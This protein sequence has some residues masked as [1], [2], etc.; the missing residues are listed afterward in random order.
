MALYEL[1][2]VRPR[3]GRDV[4]VADSAAAIGHVELGDDASV[5]FGA[6]LRGDE[7]P[8]RVGARSNVQDNAVIHIASGRGP[9]TV[10]DDVTVGHAAIL[11]ACTVGHACLI[12]MGAI[13]STAP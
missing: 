1:K 12:G 3:L 9:T 8:I 6:V 10:G 2:G 7:C 5:W 13:V 4:F 11:H